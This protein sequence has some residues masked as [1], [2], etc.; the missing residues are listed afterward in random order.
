MLDGGFATFDGDRL[1]LG[2]VEARRVPLWL[3]ARAL[4]VYAGLL[5][6]ALLGLLAWAGWRL[7]R[8]LRAGSVQ[9]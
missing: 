8:R 3:S 7:L 9:A 1:F 6:L 4:F 5:A 2:F